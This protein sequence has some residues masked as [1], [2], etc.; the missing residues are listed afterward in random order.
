MRFASLPEKGQ[1]RLMLRPTQAQQQRSL[2]I[3]TLLVSK[4]SE[5]R[6]PYPEGSKCQNRRISIDWAIPLQSVNYIGRR[7]LFGVYWAVHFFLAPDHIS[8]I[9]MGNAFSSS[10]A[11]VIQTNK[12]WYYGGE[13]V[14]GAVA[15]NCLNQL[16]T[17]GIQLEV[18]LQQQH[19]FPRHARLS[20]RP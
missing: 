5:S 11:L 12:P 3:V 1:F 14:E 13:S 9:T 15:L 6:R 2:G 10:N 19:V 7:D 4:R 16:E 8:V 18:H 20:S 17:S